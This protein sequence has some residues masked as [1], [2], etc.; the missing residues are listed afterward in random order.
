MASPRKPQDP[1]PDDEVWQNE[2]FG[3]HVMIMGTGAQAHV[4]GVE[5][6]RGGQRGRTLPRSGGS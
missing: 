3:A 6:R 5:F 2:G 4:Q 1:R